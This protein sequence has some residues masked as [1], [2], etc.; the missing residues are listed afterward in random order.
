MTSELW[1]L[2]YTITTMGAHENT[3]VINIYKNESVAS[4]V[5][6]TPASN[7][8]SYNEDNDNDILLPLRGSTGYVR[9][10]YEGQSLDIMPETM[11]DRYVEVL[12]NGS[13][14]WQGFLVPE[15]F[16][17]PWESSPYEIEIPC[18]SVLSVLEAVN[19]PVPV[20]S[21]GK[22]TFEA[23]LVEA[24]DQLMG[25]EQNLFS[26]FYYP[27]GSSSNSTFWNKTLDEAHQTHFRC[28]LF[29]YGFCEE[30]ES[31]EG[32]N[33][34]GIL[35]WSW[36]KVFSE[37]LRLFG[38][39]LRYWGGSL[40]V[41]IPT[42]E[43]AYLRESWTEVRNSGS[44]HVQTANS[45]ALLSGVSVES[46]DNKANERR[47]AK[48]VVMEAKPEEIDF[49]LS[50]DTD[51]FWFGS[52]EQET[53]IVRGDYNIRFCVCSTSQ[54]NLDNWFETTPVVFDAWKTSENSSHLVYSYTKG[55][56]MNGLT[57]AE[58][59][60]S[61]LRTECYG[62][63]RI[64]GKCPFKK[65]PRYGGL[66]LKGK[67]LKTY[68]PDTSDSPHLL[69]SLDMGRYWWGGGR[70]IY[71][72]T[73]TEIRTAFKVPLDENG[74]IT[75]NPNLDLSVYR[76]YSSSDG[77][78]IPFDSTISEDDMEEVPTLVVMKPFGYSEN[79]Y[80]VVTE[81]TLEYVQGTTVYNTVA[82]EM[83]WSLLSQT[84]H[85]YGSN[86]W[87]WPYDEGNE[88][89]YTV[90]MNVSN[91]WIDS[92]GKESLYA[93]SI[94]LITAMRYFPLMGSRR[95]FITIGKGYAPSVAPHTVLTFNGKT[96]KVLS[97][98][99]NTYD[100]NGQIIVFETNL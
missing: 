23:M 20:D 15:S 63:F 51:K 94:Y 14:F 5:E 82:Y 12:R 46:A 80:Q 35:G 30:A 71:D 24:F 11:T 6:L 54:P 83:S 72:S 81:L 56:R 74:N 21:I 86:K 84:L 85:E 69:V 49:T 4:V 44:T 39:T 9:Y 1:H 66:L 90:E 75:T 45:T 36:A 55:L 65:Q 92:A 67:A 13:M 40:Y 78:L 7:A 32:A 29:K 59:S 42:S 70:W 8:F 96:Y 22:T 16:D 33:A 98:G 64:R 60:G 41:T 17:Q 61:I 93:P 28:S 31:E 73:G 57:T 25:E 88:D 18:Q 43:R 62:G 37:Y 48:E 26:Y 58:P 10:I 77:Y 27:D 53:T 97:Q 95:E 52:Q 100:E 34:N 47:G 79:D 38:A 87:V 91:Y 50:I 89:S 99:F 76:Q 3:Y 68:V 2:A 19:M